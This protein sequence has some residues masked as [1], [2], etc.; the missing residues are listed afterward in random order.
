MK[1][2]L[3]IMYKYIILILTI[4]TITSCNSDEEPYSYLSQD[5]SKAEIIELKFGLFTEPYIFENTFQAKELFVEWGNGATSDYVFANKNDSIEKIK[6]LSYTYAA[7]G[8]YDITIKAMQMSAISLTG[9]SGRQITGIQLTNAY[10]L[11]RLTCDNLSITAI[12]LHECPL[13]NQLVLTNNNGLDIQALNN[14]FESLPLADDGEYRVIVLDGN[15]GDLGCNRSIATSK[16]WIFKS[17]L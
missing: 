10:E 2:N 12:D 13:L 5:D 8:E 3:R 15:N 11:Q 1:A 7:V 6:P 16:G 14:T 9:T 17:S 4:L